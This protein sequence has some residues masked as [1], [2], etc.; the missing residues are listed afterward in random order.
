MT[1]FALLLL[2]AAPAAAQR[3]ARTEA[4]PFLNADVDARPVALGGAYVALAGDANAVHYNPSGLA[5]M[6]GHEVTLTYH[7]LFA[8]FTQQY[9]AFAHKLSPYTGVG[10]QFNTYGAGSIQRTS[11]ADPNGSTLGGVAA[12]D[13]AA[14]LAFGHRLKGQAVAFGGAVKVIRSTLDIYTAQTFAFDAGVMVQPKG[15]RYPVLLAASVHNLGAGLDY[16]GGKEALPTRVRLGASVG[17]TR[18]ALMTSEVRLTQDGMTLHAGAEYRLFEHVLLRAGYD[19]RDAAGAGFNLAGALAGGGGL[20]FGRFG[21]D[22]AFTPMGALGA[23]H[24]MSLSY[25]FASG[26]GSA[27]R[28]K[29]ARPKPPAGGVKTKDLRELLL[30]R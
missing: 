6:P 3:N 15:V 10:A 24:R 28:F 2:L 29:S 17:L 30:S 26:S 4:L 9:G 14:S 1:F 16:G 18:S 27:R 20:E 5:L 25:R 8:G 11:A 7:Q 22:Y 12:R 13:S 23:A 21:M 19:G